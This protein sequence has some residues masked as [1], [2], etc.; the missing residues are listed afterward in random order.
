MVLSSR[1]SVSRSASLLGVFGSRAKAIQQDFEDFLGTVPLVL[2][3]GHQAIQG[4]PFQVAGEPT[5]FLFFRQVFFLQMQLY[6]FN[7]VFNTTIWFILITS[8]FLENP[9]RFLAALIGPKQ[10]RE[11][12]LQGL[13]QI[14]KRHGH[15]CWIP[16]IS[17]LTV[18]ICCLRLQN[19]PPVRVVGL[20]SSPWFEWFQF[21]ESLFRLAC[22]SRVGRLFE[23]GRLPKE[24]PLIF[25]GFLGLLFLV[26]LQFELPLPL[27][28]P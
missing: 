1:W 8:W 24:V 22:A 18:H 4:C 5:T 23:I 16:W 28:D 13:V 14:F 12:S 10:S 17:H 25:V 21:R 26:A 27:V 15:C 11:K 9:F 2:L 20:S 7:P 6:D 3:L 19:F